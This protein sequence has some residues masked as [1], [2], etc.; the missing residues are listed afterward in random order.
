MLKSSLTHLTI[1]L[2]QV[3][4]GSTGA[5]GQGPIDT[6]IIGITHHA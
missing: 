2:A 3:N 1:I 6:H 4:D 5:I